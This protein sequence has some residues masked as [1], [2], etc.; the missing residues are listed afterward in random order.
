[1][2]TRGIQRKRGEKVTV[3]L[4]DSHPRERDSARNENID[5]VLSIAWGAKFKVSS[6]VWRDDVVRRSAMAEDG[7][8]AK[9][10]LES[11][12]DEKW[13]G[14]RVEMSWRMARTSHSVESRFAWLSSAAFPIETPR[15]K[16]GT[17]AIFRRS[18]R[19]RSER[20]RHV[21]LSARWLHHLCRNTNQR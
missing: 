20:A 14:N 9:D 1:M 6:D 10:T 12:Q 3:S 16:R 2:R 13:K 18:T 21:S 5:G 4:S 11:R 15:Y 7:S 17:M 19:T 8:L